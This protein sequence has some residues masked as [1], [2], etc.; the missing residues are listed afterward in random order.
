MVSFAARTL[1]KPQE[2][3]NTWRFLV[4][5]VLILYVAWMAYSALRDARQNWLGLLIATGVLIGLAKQLH[6][7]WKAARPSPWTMIEVRTE[8]VTL[9]GRDSSF[10]Q[11]PL[12]KSYSLLAAGQV[13]VLRWGQP[14]PK[15]CRKVVFRNKQDM[16]ETD[17][18]GLHR[19]L[20][21][22]APSRKSM[23]PFASV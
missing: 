2:R 5:G 7:F 11:L 18:E 4:Q 1:D 21:E 15:R 13:L 23:E 6:D 10:Y 12:P 14:A 3:R 16:T 17:F 20:Q 8:N 22:V 9:H 19:V